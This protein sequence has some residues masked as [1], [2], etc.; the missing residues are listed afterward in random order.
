VLPIHMSARRDLY[1]YFPKRRITKKAL[2]ESMRRL[3]GLI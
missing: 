3:K 2:M 1:L